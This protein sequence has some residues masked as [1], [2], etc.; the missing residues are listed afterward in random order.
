MRVVNSPRF[1]DLSPK[2]IVPILAEEGRYVASESTIYRLL[3]EE[4]QLQH[5]GL[6]RAPRARP[7]PAEKVADGPNQLW[8]WDITYLPTS[9]R[10]RFY[11]LYMVVDVWS[12]KVVGAGVYEKE[13]SKFA[14]ELISTCFAREGSKPGLILHSD[15]GAPMKGATLLATLQGLGVT[16]SFSRPR[17]SDDNPYSE[18]LFRTVKYRPGYP[19]VFT[20]VAMATEWVESFVDWYNTKH[21]HSG[22]KFVTPEQRHAG[23][24][25]AILQA[26]DDTYQAACVIN[27]ERWSG[28]TR[29]WAP[30]EVVKLNSR[31]ADEGAA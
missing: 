19:S 17:V 22:I 2:Q 29:N 18:S 13:R 7:R 24:E 12:R 9:V 15:N 16:T 14:S 1:R 28:A 21:R 10:G 23:R 26:R 25:R 6:T 4:G 31:P 11:Y 27:P 30:V 8:T 3:R 20:S 5:R